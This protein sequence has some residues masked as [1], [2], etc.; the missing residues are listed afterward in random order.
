MMMVMFLNGSMSVKVVVLGVG[1]D[2][3][4]MARRLLTACMQVTKG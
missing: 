2:E 3:Q 1:E 4:C